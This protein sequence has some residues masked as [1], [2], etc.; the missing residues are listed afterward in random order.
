ME[1]IVCV[2]VSEVQGQRNDLLNLVNRVERF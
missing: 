2:Y 1:G